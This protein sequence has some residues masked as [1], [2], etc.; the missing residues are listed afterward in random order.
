MRTWGILAFVAIAG[1]GDNHDLSGPRPLVPD[2]AVVV[3]CVPGPLGA[4]ATRA[5]VVACSEELIGGR[6]AGGRV[7]DFVLE[8]AKLRAIIRGRGE[9]FYQHGSFG[10]GLV[11]VAAVGGEDLIKEIQPTIDLAVGAFDELVITEAGD[12]GDAEIVV[13]GP[14]TSLEIIS[15]ALDRVPPPVIVEHHYRLAKDAAV[16]ELE[17]KAFPVAG[18]EATDLTLFEAMFTGGRARA[19]LPGKGW[20][21]GQ[22][23]AE[24]IATD[25]T[26]SSYAFVY[27]AETPNPQLIDLGGIRVIQ[28]PSIDASGLKRWLVVGDGSIASVTDQGWLLRGETLGEISGRTSPGARVVIRDLADNLVTIGRGAADGTYRALVPVGDYV[29]QAEAEGH[30]AGVDVPG[31]VSAGRH[32]VA[33]VPVGP[34]G[35]LT[36]FAHD[37]AATPLPARVV[38]EQPGYDRRIHYTGANGMLSVAMPPGTARVSVSRGLE[39]D[40]FVASALAITDGGTANLDVTLSH[41]LDTAGWIS[42]DTHLHSELSTD[43]TFPVDDRLRAVAAEGVEVPVSADHDFIT[44]YAP[45]IAELGLGNWVRSLDGEEVSSIVWGHTIGF[46]LVSDPAKTAHGGAH[47][48]RKSPAEVFARLHASPGAI[49][50]I[51]HPRRSSSDFFNAIELDPD[52]LVAQRDPTDLGLPATTD[53]SALDFD[54]FEV[55]NVVADNDFEVVFADFL[56]MVAVGHPAAATGSTDSHGA[57]AFAGEARTYV[58]V[59]AGAD[60]PV[61]VSPEAI[62]DAIRARRVVVGTGAFV[63]A[64]IVGATST[65]LPGDTATVAAGTPIKLHIKIQAPPWQPLSGIRIYER[66][67]QIMSIPLSPADTATVRFDADVTLAAATTDTFFVVR[68][69]LAGAGDPVLDTPMPSFTNPVFVHVP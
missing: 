54:A 26:T 12:D 16:I 47:W 19:F 60:D 51:N 52:T 43:S 23:G 8:N 59:G 69:E 5:K 53:L 30:A 49:V 56:A 37:D 42:L 66:K 1:C 58:Y 15:A 57:G 9:G 36:I 25:G 38:I 40:A 2:P 55:A 22:G 4:G 62:T 48:L 18:A 64:G 41:V 63:T 33:D 35:T 68:V 34:A 20:A 67:Q 28:G 50:Q 21:A 27:P 11:D 65:S 39:Y 45:I 13:R 6:L 31:L 7:G 10:G 32:V 29:L 3:G 46:P 14:A 61:T 24:M 44:E 17:T